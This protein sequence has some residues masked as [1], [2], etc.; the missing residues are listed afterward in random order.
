MANSSDFNLPQIEEEVLALWERERVFERSVAEREGSPRF[1]VYD[2]PPTANAKPAL[3]H[4]LPGMFK[5]A[6]ARYKTMRGFQVPRQQGWDTHGLPVEVQ[7][8]RALELSSKQDVTT[9]VPG[10]ERAS[11]AAFNKACR[12]SVWEFKQEWDKFQPRYG[13]WLDQEKPYITYETPYI[14]GVWS[15]VKRVFEKGLIFK[16]YKVLPYCPR[17]GTGLSAAEVA[18]GYEDVSDVSVYVSFPIVEK[19]GVSFLAWTTTPWTLPGNVALAVG[20]D[21]DYVEV[22]QRAETGEEHRYIL[23]RE[24]LGIL[25]GEYEVLENYRGSELVGLTYAPLYPG[26]L[27]D[28][29]GKRHEVV[30]A[31]FVTT[32]DG[33]GIVHT[34]VMY[35]EDDFQL[36]TKEGLCKVHTVG[37]D[38]RFLP[39]VVEL[40]GL[41]VDEA[42][43]PILKDLTVKQALYKKER[44][45]HSY[46]H[47][48]RC[49]ARLLYYAK[50]SWY[51]G[52][53]QLRPQ[54][55]AANEQV[56]WIPE[57]IKQ[58]RFGDFI[59]E[60]RDWAISRER[61]WGT[62]LPIWVAPS[63]KLRCVGSVAELRELAT[64]P[65]QIPVDVDLHRPF[66][67]DITLTIEG[68]EYIREPYVLDVWLDSGS[69]PYAS[70]RLAA[71]QFPADYIA[72][73]VDQTRGWFYSLLALSTALEEVPAYRTVVCFGHLVDEQGKKMSKSVGNIIDPWEIFT[74]HG[75]DAL[76]WYIFTLNAP[77]ET[78]AFSVRDLQTA[79]RN[80]HLL[81]WNVASYYHTYR[82]L[83][84]FTLP[85]EEDVAAL[86]DSTNPLDRWI[87][88][89]LT[90]TQLEVEGHFDAFDYLRGG[91]VIEAFVQDLS[92][93]YLRRS[94]KRTDS[95]FFTVLYACLR[96]TAGF[97]APL[98]PFL[99]EQIYQELRREGDPV[100]IH[101]TDWPALVSVSSTELVDEMARLRIAVELG[102]RVRA[103]QGVK[104]R[105]PLAQAVIASD[106]PFSDEL[107]AILLDELNVAA[108]RQEAL[109]DSFAASPMSQG[110]TVG[111]DLRMTPE[112]ERAGLVRELT[113]QLQQLR[114]QVGLEPGD[115]TKLWVAPQHRARLDEWLS[116]ELLHELAITE[117]I[118][119]PAVVHELKLGG[120]VLL[121]ALG[122]TPHVE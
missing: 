108:V 57:H 43:V 38:G 10:D 48:W 26:A 91:R 67:D 116:P 71:S 63:G 104:V 76:R 49:K 114:K 102:Q 18:Q 81:L 23:A 64:H 59:R 119:A 39:E 41:P 74:T 109:P 8:E 78:K 100:S 82:K 1:I 14:E 40:A 22:A 33:T 70:G 21:I 122:E 4:T 28:T 37:L 47:C 120:D 19:P 53:S 45:T 77:G 60:A 73:A 85:S 94:R 75:A 12:Q 99:P 110:I 62:P 56:T 25:V 52:M 46:P 24:R 17:C 83:A 113:R 72:E 106:Q 97:L 101:L 79:Y 61:F 98:T 42:L 32:T 115:S 95:E 107:L 30:P 121:V 50:D 118:E 7:V 36:G 87:L 51:I 44:I 93:W 90:A 3:H 117:V 80:T 86:G 34:A 66:I 88:S 54:L 35:G 15:V 27:G 103:E 111:I 31:D 55:I 92:T 13:Y 29:P 96:S 112:L 68:E 84:E 105:Q 6:A 9:I 89:R 65:D 16:D 5:D 11:I 58:G 20:A 69:M 2:G